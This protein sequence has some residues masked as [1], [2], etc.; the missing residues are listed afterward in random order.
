MHFLRFNAFLLFTK[1]KF[2][3]IVITDMKKADKQKTINLVQ[4][5]LTGVVNQLQYIEDVIKYQK[6]EDVSVLE[7]LEK[8]KELKKSI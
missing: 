5:E 6:L 8:V 1:I 3:H 2:W 4:E 7:L